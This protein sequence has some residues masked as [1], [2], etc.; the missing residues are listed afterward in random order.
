M[1]PM[2]RPSLWSLT[3]LLLTMLGLLALIG[4]AG[5]SPWMHQLALVGWVTLMRASLTFWV[6]SNRSALQQDE[7]QH[8]D[9][10]VH[11]AGGAEPEVMMQPQRTLPLTP[12]QQHYL[13]VMHGRDQHY[14]ENSR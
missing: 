3:I 12:V 4:F 14:H 7:L 9:E 6:R 1:K 11:S 2:P 5:L 8:R 10:R 13:E